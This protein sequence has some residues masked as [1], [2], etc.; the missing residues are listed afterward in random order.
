MS[1]RTSLLLAPWVLAALGAVACAGSNQ[2][3]GYAPDL[4][5]GGAGDPDASTPTPVF[6]GD[7]GD[8]AAGP[9]LK[10]TVLAPNGDMPIAGALVYLTNA[11]PAPAPKGVFCDKCV[12]LAADQYALSGA[13]GTFT[14]PAASAGSRFLVVQKGGFRLVSDLG[15]VKA[16][17]TLPAALTTLP[18]KADPAQ[19]AEVPKMTVV[20]GQYDDIESSLQKLGIDPTAID[21][22]QSALI[23]EAAKAFLRDPVAV[24]AQQIIFLPCGDLTQGGVNIDLSSDTTIQANLKSFVAQG[25]RLYVTDWHYDF[26]NRTFP[27]YV[28]WSGASATACSGCEHVSYDAPAEVDDPALASWL[29]AQSIGTFQLLRN[30]TTI[31]AVN[32]VSA[33]VSGVTATVTPKVWVR[34]KK[35]AAATAAT[36]SFEYG[37]GR[38]LFSTYHAEPA[39]LALTPQERALLGVLLEVNV[40]NDSPSGVVVK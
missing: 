25:G 33:E 38:V 30:Y 27:G 17:A 20:A 10:G 14:L 24:L 35:S 2:V 31:D 22:R 8:A 28:T 4:A 16:D 12:E 19:N 37:C 6:A 34:S 39:T 26:L 1:S 7:G 3:L 13:D 9:H 18:S 15:S 36:V 21:L 5:D 23:G 40:C 32:A 11:K 29:G